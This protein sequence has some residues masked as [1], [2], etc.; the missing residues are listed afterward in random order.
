[1]PVFFVPEI[2]PYLRDI[3]GFA[4]SKRERLFLVGGSLRDALL[5]RRKEDIDIDFC[6]KKGA[7]PFGR[8]LSRALGA[9]FVVLDE[10]FGSCRLVKKD[11]DKIYTFDFTDFR[12][13]SLKDDLLHRDFTINTLALDLESALL[14]HNPERFLID[15]YGAREDLNKKSLRLVNRRAFDEDPLRI[16]RAFSLSCVLNFKIDKGTLAL[17][18]QKRKRLGSVSGERIRDELFKILHSNSAYAFFLELDKLGILK[19]VIPEIEVMRGVKQGPYHHLDVFRHSLETIRQM[20]M[21]IEDSRKKRDINNYLQEVI[22]GARKRFSLMKLAALLHDIGKPDARRRKGGKI[23]FYGHER[24]GAKFTDI[25]ARRLKLSNDESEALKK[26]VFW[27]LR[28]GYL[29]DSAHLTP[30]AKFRY[31]RDAGREAVSILILSLADQRSTRG[32]LTTKESRLRHEKVTAALMAESF[33]RSRQVKMVRL[34]NGD[35]LIKK[36]KLKP[37]PLIGRLLS[38][39]EEL[40]AIGKMKSKAQGFRLVKGLIRKFQAAA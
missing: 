25:I 9:G 40:Q 6:I 33:R 32:P 1:M 26:M 11:R 17:I 2:I 37:S 15:F 4:A 22:S 7:I 30:R 31:F 16:L 5:K 29:G 10:K 36:F 35:D 34:V 27:H 12:G 28:P 38:E 20:E 18:K 13:K 21:F 19:L 24:I 39:L 3:L 23:K 14:A 8:A